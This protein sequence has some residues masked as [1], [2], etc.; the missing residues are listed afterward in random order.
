VIQLNTDNK[1]TKQ[2]MLALTT[3]RSAYAPMETT[4]V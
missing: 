3:I 4:A 2:N 1:H